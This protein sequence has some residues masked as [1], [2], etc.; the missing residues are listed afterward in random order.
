MT[1]L[2]LGKWTHIL[3]TLTVMITSLLWIHFMGFLMFINLLYLSASTIQVY[4]HS[5]GSPWWFYWRSW[6][7]ILFNTSPFQVDHCLL[8]TVPLT[9]FNMLESRECL[10]VPNGWWSLHLN[11]G[12]ILIGSFSHA[13]CFPHPQQPLISLI[14]AQVF[15]WAYPWVYPYLSSCTLPLPSLCNC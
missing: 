4:H 14:Y 1:Q 8:R 15:P 6:T 5:C 11:W 10:F 2:L 7:P 9:L 3:T 13:S 12:L